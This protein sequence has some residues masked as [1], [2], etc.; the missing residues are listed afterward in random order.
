MRL[1]NKVAIVTG[2]ASGMGRASAILFAKEGASVT[3]ADIDEAG[4]QETVRTI[5][6]SGGK[7][8]FVR[9]DVAKSEDV[10]NMIHT[11]VN[12]FGK[13][14]ILFNNAGLAQ[15]AIRFDK[16]QESDWDR[17][18]AVN[19]KAIFLGAKHAVPEMKKAGGGVIIITVSIGAVRVRPGILA[20]TGAKSAAIGITK[21]LAL[22]LARHNIRV[23]CIN[24]VATMTP[25]LTMFQPDANISM[26][27]A[28]KTM[29]ETI[30]LGHVATPEDIAYA[31]LYLASDESAM[32]TGASIN[33]DGG[34]G[35]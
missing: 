27:E 14:D 4:G 16:I 20:Y 12:S 19:A 29:S 35:I 25:M 23:N 10:K 7:A 34:R 8:I 2:A 30:P 5:K 28:V 21:G 33:V 32:V 18:F 6:D 11:T 1:A 22:E 3:V 24:P 9:T 13:L 15:R 31:A 26:E 17:I